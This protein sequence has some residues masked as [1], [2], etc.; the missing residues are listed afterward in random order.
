MQIK[1]FLQV[2][3]TVV[4]V[5]VGMAN[6]LCDPAY[7]RQSGQIVTI[8]P[9]NADD[10]ANL[11]CAFQL[12]SRMPGVVL[13]LSKGTYITGRIK[14]DGFVGTVRGKGM[15]ST[16]IRNSETPIYVTP[17][18]FY[19]V[20]PNTD[21]FAPPYLIV[22][23]G[24]DYTV[25]DLTVSIVGSEPA[26]DWSIFGIRD[27]LG[28]GVKS[29]AGPFTILGT[30][31]GNGY[32]KANAAFYRMK[33]TG[34]LSNDPLYGYNIYNGIFY[35][36]L[37]GPDLQPLKGRFT[38]HDSVFETVASPTPVF[39]LRDS[40]VSLSGNK[41]NNVAPGSV[42][43][44]VIDLKHTVYEFSNNQVAGSSGV[45]MYDNCLGG[46]SNCGMQGSELLVTN[47]HFRTSDGV[48]IDAS[49]SRATTALVLGNDFT[50]VSGLGVRLGPDTSKCLVV[51]TA[52]TSVED[53]G[54]GNL[55]IG[56][57]QAA[58]SGAHARSLRLGKSH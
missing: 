22:F 44:E 19:Q 6:A 52:P 26:T 58:S 31:S 53:L 48:L 21:A 56:P 12:G 11:Q 17:D 38:V 49:F 32:R 55:V 5:G 28:H 13:Q 16:I 23:L 3:V 50:K 37:T 9:T 7:V 35:Q 8:L 43:G 57:K 39:N 33:L 15:N 45:I 34:E 24:G 27:W 25:T 2:A 41:M 18:D 30:P 20:D 29:L 42:G 46:E 14:V 36:G 4:L 10:T 47:N 1:R 51:L 54:T 40:W